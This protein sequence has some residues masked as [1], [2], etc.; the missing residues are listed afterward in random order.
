M[1]NSKAPSRRSVRFW[2]LRGMRL[3]ARHIGLLANAGVSEHPGR[4]PATRADY[5]LPNRRE[6]GAWEDSN[7]PMI[8]AAVERDGGI[9]G[10][11]VAVERNQMAI[12]GALLEPGADVALVIG[13]T[14]PGTR[15]SLGGR[16]RRSGRTCD[17]L[18]WRCCR[19]RRLVLAVHAGGV[20]VVLLPGSPAA[21]LWGYELFAGRAIR[22]LGGRDPALP[23][24]SREMSHRAKDR[25]GYRHDRDLPGAAWL[26]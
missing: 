5:W 10:E 12:R 13:G 4:A 6:T 7:G 20:P 18:A 22:R 21:C 17:P 9:V 19:A 23:Y 11:C 2:R 3:A 14:G 24:R 1:S 26:R 15:R 8:C 16:A 25:L